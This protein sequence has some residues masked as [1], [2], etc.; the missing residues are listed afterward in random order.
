MPPEGISRLYFL[1]RNQSDRCT[2]IRG[3]YEWY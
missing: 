1:I 3:M 2:N